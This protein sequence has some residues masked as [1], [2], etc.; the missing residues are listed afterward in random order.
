MF[1]VRNLNLQQCCVSRRECVGAGN[2]YINNDPNLHQFM[3]DTPDQ[4]NSMWNRIQTELDS[5][6]TDLIIRRLANQ[7][8]NNRT[9]LPVYKEDL[10]RLLV[11]DW[12]RNTVIDVFDWKTITKQDIAGVPNMYTQFRIMEGSFMYYMYDQYG[13]YNYNGC[14]RMVTNKTVDSNGHVISFLSHE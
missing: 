4:V 14:R 3:H 12:V 5:F 9:R 8:D 7:I 13:I 2:L 1:T 6:S 11:G 10:E